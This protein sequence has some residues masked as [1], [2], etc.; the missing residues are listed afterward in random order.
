MTSLFSY[1][2]TIFG[3]MYWLFRVII[4]ITYTMDVDIGIEPLNYNIEIILLFVTLFCMILI[5]KRNIFGALIYFICYGLYFGTDVYNS[6]TNII[7]GQ[8][9]IAGYVNLLI[10]LLG[11]LIPFLIVM[12]IFLNKNR[13]SSGKDKKTDWFYTNKEYDRELDKRADKNQYKF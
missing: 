12:D 10:S 4:S 7:N 6:I 3:G 1:L 8:I 9:D 5:I 2:V 13:Q 11:V